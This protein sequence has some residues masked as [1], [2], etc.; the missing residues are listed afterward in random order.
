MIVN[1]ARTA[2]QAAG[3][4]G[5]PS[6]VTWGAA[7]RRARAPARAWPRRSDYVYI[8]SGGQRRR[9]ASRPPWPPDCP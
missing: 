2:G 1:G 9:P 6:A 5:V 7:R 8:G 4:A 3:R